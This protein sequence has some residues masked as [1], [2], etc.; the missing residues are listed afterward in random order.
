M[1]KDILKDSISTKQ[2]CLN[3]ELLIKNIE[4]AIKVITNAIQK[5]KKLLIMGN[6]GSAADAQHFAGEFIN[7]FLMERKPL[8]AISLST[9]TSVITCIGN[10]YSFNDIF[11]KQVEALANEGDILIGITT[12]GGS[13]NILRGFRAGMDI[14]TVNIGLLGKDGGKAKEL[15]DIAIVV[16]SDKTPRIQEMHITIIHIIC[17][18]VERNIFKN[19]VNVIALD[20]PSGAGKSTVAKILSEKFGY[21]YI[22]T[23]AMYRIIGLL[24]DGQ[25]VFNDDEGLKKLLEDIKGKIRFK[26]GR[27]FLDNIDYTDKIYENRVS[28][29]ASDVSK[30]SIVREVLGALQREIGLSQKSV[31]EGRDIGTV[32]FPDAKYKFFID[33]TA[34]ERAKR[35]YLELKEKGENVD[36]DKI[37]EEIK[38]RDKN[39]STRDIAPLKKAADAVYI[40][41]TG[42]SAEEVAKKII[43]RIKHGNY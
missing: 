18:I 28:M 30:K 25:D 16:K 39:D 22:S 15:C 1:I 6:G 37:L 20:G 9:D 13:E 14:G 19:K 17:E 31:L 10:D 32:I 40:D 42:I 24:A 33:A 36:Y 8:P 4:L 12:S 2:Q 11:K 41:T 5:G 7:R 27:I 23:G 34:E 3:D 43:N 35:R 21:E 26:N 38:K 29:L